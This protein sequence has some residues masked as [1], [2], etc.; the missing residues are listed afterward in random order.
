MSFLKDN[1]FDL[2]IHHQLFNSFHLTWF[3]WV[4][5]FWK[6]VVLMKMVVEFFGEV[7]HVEVKVDSERRLVH[8]L[9]L[10]GPKT[11]SLTN[12]IS[13]LFQERVMELL[14]KLPYWAYSWIFYH[15]DGRVCDFVVWR[16]RLV[17]EQLMDLEDDDL[18]LDREFFAVALKRRVLNGI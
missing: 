1:L 11:L 4:R 15:G 13:A 2:Q 16:G 3:N 14:E 7:T 10:K 6:G 12:A 8:V 9:D 17:G 5:R 18:R